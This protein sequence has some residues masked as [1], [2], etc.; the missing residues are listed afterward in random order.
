MRSTYIVASIL[1][2]FY[3]IA[4][5]SHRYDQSYTAL[6][7][8]LNTI[9]WYCVVRGSLSSRWFFICTLH[10]GMSSAANTY[11]DWTMALGDFWTT[12]AR[13]VLFV[14]EIFFREKILDTRGDSNDRPSSYK[15][16]ISPLG[17]REP[18]N[19]S[20]NLIKNTKML[21]FCRFVVRLLLFIL[22]FINIEYEVR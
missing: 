17:Y 3:I 7:P 15:A 19:F 13:T 12:K 18:L 21:N 2:I 20:Q 11:P 1:S 9:Q 16:G 14:T 6:R 4:Y 5:W 8:L 10:S 22:D